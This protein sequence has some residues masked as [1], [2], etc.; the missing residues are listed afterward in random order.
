METRKRGTER[1]WRRGRKRIEEEK[2]EKAA[3]VEEE[4]RENER[5]R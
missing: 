5:G 3:E 2:E 4:G 1:K